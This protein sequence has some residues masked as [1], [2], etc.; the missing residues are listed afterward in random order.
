MSRFIVNSF[1]IP[2]AIVDELMRHLSGNALKCYL[3]I[4]RNTTGWGKSSDK[5]SIDQFLRMTGIKDKR[6][7]IS[8]LDE[9]V[10]LNLISAVKNNGVITEF[11]LNVVEPVTKND[12]GA[13][14]D[15]G[16]NFC[17]SPVTKNV[18]AT[19]S[20]KC[21][22]TK[23][24][25][26]YIK[27]NIKNIYKQKNDF[28]FLPAEENPEDPVKPAR[29]NKPKSDLDLSVFHEQ[30]SDEVW[31]DFLQHRKN[32]KVPLTQSAVKLLA[33]EV[34]QAVREGY[35][36][37]YVLSHVMASGW[38]GFKFSW[39]QNQERTKPKNTHQEQINWDNTD[40]AKGLLV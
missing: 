19:S 15:T 6:T 30:P 23:Y 9:L 32:I 20:K 12:T 25:N 13:K 5:I 34:N 28:V 35:T 4:S 11:F 7:V 36:T 37:D 40:W 18:T 22:S 2:N 10:K 31:S 21:H 3:L 24:N 27:Q 38:R 17:M 16:D 1:Q 14:N 39:L 29:K 26:K 33:G 8:D